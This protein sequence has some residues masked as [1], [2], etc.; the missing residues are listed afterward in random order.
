MLHGTVSQ[1][2]GKLDMA[3]SIIILMNKCLYSREYD[4]TK[5]NETRLNITCF[6][7]NNHFNFLSIF[8]HL[9]FLRYL[10]KVCKSQEKD[11]SQ[12]TPQEFIDHDSSLF[13]NEC[14]KAQ[15]AKGKV[16]TEYILNTWI[17]L[18]IWQ[19]VVFYVLLQKPA[20]SYSVT[21]CY[22]LHTSKEICSWIRRGCNFKETQISVCAQNPESNL[23]TCLIYYRKYY[24][25]NL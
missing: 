4:D 23:L 16:V 9:I 17:A 19:C 25:S 15:K 24:I 21:A 6:E 20:N 22:S 14:K 10:A 12:L 8:F 2:W 5:E 11:K 13:R 18:Q 3:N 1:A 7:Q